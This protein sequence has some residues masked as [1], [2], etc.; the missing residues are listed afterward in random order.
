MFVLYK[1]MI[2]SSN[3]KGFPAVLGEIIGWGIVS[4]CSDFLTKK[5]SYHIAKN[6]K[7]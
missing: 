7:L 6:F 1:S 3:Y 2:K 4:L 5:Y